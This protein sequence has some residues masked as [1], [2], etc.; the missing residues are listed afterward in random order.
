MVTDAAIKLF[1]FINIPNNLCK[2]SEKPA[3]MSTFA[4]IFK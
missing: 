4:L 3:F 1:F 2:F